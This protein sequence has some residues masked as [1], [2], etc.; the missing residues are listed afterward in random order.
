MIVSDMLPAH[1]YL[2]R[3]F[4]SPMLRMVNGEVSGLH[5]WDLI[6]MA[7]TDQETTFIFE[8]R[9]ALQSSRGSYVMACRRAVVKIETAAY[10]VTPAGTREL[11]PEQVVNDDGR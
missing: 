8:T 11:T 3:M 7:E 4:T 6:H 5:G 1:L 10:S 2:R 9:Q